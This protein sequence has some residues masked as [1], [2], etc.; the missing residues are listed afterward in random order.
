MTPKLRSLAKSFQRLFR[1][2]RVTA[3]HRRATPQRTSA[4]EMRI[5]IGTQP[6]RA[7]ADIFEVISHN[8]PVT[9]DENLEKTAVGL[10]ALDKRSLHVIHGMNV[11]N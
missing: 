11:D 8:P 5:G 7:L 9:I 3:D 10:G 2:R 6:F 4:I 1:W